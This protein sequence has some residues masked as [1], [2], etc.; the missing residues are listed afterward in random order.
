MKRFLKRV[1][2]VFLIILVLVQI[3]FIYR[4]YQLGKL[5][6]QRKEAMEYY[7][8]EP[9]GNEQEGRSSVVSRDV[10]DTVEWIMPSLMRIFTGG[11]KVVEFQPT[12]MEDEPAAKQEKSGSKQDKPADAVG[13]LRLRGVSSAWS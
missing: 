13:N 12:G 7:L 3:P 9:F 11:D 5:A 2:L 1:F 6:E 10:A 8:G 4:R